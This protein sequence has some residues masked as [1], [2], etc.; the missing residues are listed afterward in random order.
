MTSRP[1]PSATSLTGRQ[2]AGWPCIWC[3]AS[4]AITG[5][6]SVGI[7]RGRIG[8]HVLDVEVYACTPQCPSAAPPQVP[9]GAVPFTRE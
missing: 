5:G 2:Y 8:T 7:A 6:I 9:P 3:N 4:H 1:V